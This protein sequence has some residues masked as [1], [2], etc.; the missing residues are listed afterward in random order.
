MRAISDK[1]HPI[2]R[3]GR[4]LLA[5][6]G[7][8][9][10]LFSSKSVQPPYQEGEVLAWVN[11]QP[12]TSGQLTF[13][14]DRLTGGSPGSLSAAQRQAIS[15]LLIDEE[16]LLQRAESLGI[17]GTDPGVRK[18]IVQ[19]VIDSVVENFL[20]EPVDSQRLKLFY[21]QHAAVFG[22]P[23]R[24]AVEVLRFTNLPDAERAHAA[25]LS[26]AAFADVGRTAN[27][28]T[29]PQL[30]SS[31][32]PVYVLQRYLGSRLTDIALSLEQGEVSDPVKRSN[33][34][35]L[36]HTRAVTPSVVPDFNE[37]REEVEAE[38]RHRGRETALEKTLVNLWRSADIDFNQEVADGLSVTEKHQLGL[39]QYF[40]NN[41][42]SRE[43]Y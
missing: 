23:V 25:L 43:R 24:V 15:E 10:A 9:L 37:I 40:E 6:L 21:Q 5:L 30:P 27:A 33:G 8:A 4:I 38:Y 41:A 35:Y 18:A 14:M 13:A 3:T 31:P 34:V 36:L 2:V 22:R 12:V 29:I 11:Q 26:G 32:L 28:R 7:L 42:E 19:A 20:A 1:A 17:H 16:L 39:S